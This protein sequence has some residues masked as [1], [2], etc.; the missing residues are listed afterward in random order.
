MS[1]KLGLILSS[2]F[3]VMAFLFAFDLMNVQFI[4]ADLDAK[5]VNIT[6]LI[7]R[8]PSLDE[9]FYQH[10]SERYDVEMICS[11]QGATVFG[12]EIDFEL[13][14]NYKPLIMSKE[15]MTVSIKRS[16]IVGYFG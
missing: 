13:V 5:S 2:I 7:S 10:I 15:N 3:I 12:E 9:P 16:A 14:D 1:S 11:K 4:Y 8:S 6:Y